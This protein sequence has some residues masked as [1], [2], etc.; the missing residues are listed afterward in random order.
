MKDKYNNK[1][2]DLFYSLSML[3]F[4][5][6]MLLVVMCNVMADEDMVICDAGVWRCEGLCATAM[7]ECL[8]AVSFACQAD[9]DAVRATVAGCTHSPPVRP[10]LGVLTTTAPSVMRDV[11]IGSIAGVCVILASAIVVAGCAVR[12]YLKRRT[13]QPV[14]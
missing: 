8:G 10:T 9:I 12:C 7:K 13:S 11:V 14:V 2:A 4:R 6:V 5:F 1:H 3:M